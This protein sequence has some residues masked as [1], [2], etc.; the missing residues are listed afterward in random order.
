MAQAVISIPAFAAAVVIILFTAFHSQPCTSKILH[1]LQP[2]DTYSR[3]RR[4]GGG[5]DMDEEIHY[6][7]RPV[8]K[9]KA[10]QELVVHIKK[11]TSPEE[12]APK[13]K[14]VRSTSAATCII[15]VN[16]DVQQSVSSSVGIIIR[17]YH[18]GVDLG[19]NLYSQTKFRHSKR[20]LLF[21]KCCRK[22]IQS[23]VKPS[24]PTILFTD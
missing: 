8:D 5:F 12:S 24:H 15:S 9:D 19:F 18:S 11:A 17:Q 21:I 3:S 20:L 1:L 7:T 22:D 16:S 2:T 13:Q 6:P 23:C 10:E 4:H 14:H